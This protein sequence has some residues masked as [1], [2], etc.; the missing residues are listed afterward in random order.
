MVKRLKNSFKKLISGND[1]AVCWFCRE[2]TQFALYS[3]EKDDESWCCKSC[4]KTRGNIKK[5]RQVREY[6]IK[7]E[8][9]ENSQSLHGDLKEEGHLTGGLE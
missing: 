5:T 8:K 4:A 2:S 7:R 1:Y 9:I 6:V 3:A